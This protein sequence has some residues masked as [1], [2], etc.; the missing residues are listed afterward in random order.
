MGFYLF[1]F[2]DFE[3]NKRLCSDLR[4]YNVCK[5]KT[6]VKVVFFFVITSRNFLTSSIYNFHSCVGYKELL[7]CSTVQ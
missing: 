4:Q 7:N 1:W 3:I 6:V 2:V 5:K